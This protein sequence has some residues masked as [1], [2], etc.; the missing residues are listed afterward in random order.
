MAGSTVL[1]SP[2][3]HRRE[4]RPFGPRSRKLLLFFILAIPWAWALTILS[5][6][7]EWHHW[8]IG[9]ACYGLGIVVGRRPGWVLMLVGTLVMLDDWQHVGQALDPDFPR[10]G[11]RGH[12]D[13][14]PMHQ[15]AH[16]AGLI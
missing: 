3:R 5:R 8:Y 1:R 10:S 15:I 2:S 16:K 4:T 11:L 9:A 7:N 14:S 6:W 12:L 13:T